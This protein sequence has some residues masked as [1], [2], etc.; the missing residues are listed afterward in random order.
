MERLLAESDASG[1]EFVTAETVTIMRRYF[2]QAN[3]ISKSDASP[4]L[5]ADISVSVVIATYDRPDSLHKC[6]RSLLGQQTSRSIEVIVVDNHPASHLTPPVLAEFPEVIFV[7]DPRQGLS[8]ARNAGIVA[9]KGEIIIT[10]D[11]DV[12]MPS[13]WLE[14]VTPFV[15][16]DVMVVTGNV[17]PIELETPAQKLFELY[18]GLQRGFRR[19]EADGNWF[20]SFKRCAVP[21]WELGSTAN[22]AFRASLFSDSQIGLFDKRLVQVQRRAAAKTPTCSIRLS[23]AVIRFSTSQ[24]PMFGTSAA[25]ISQTFADKSTQLQQGSRGIT[26]NDIDPRS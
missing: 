21:T 10:T 8:Y 26:F 1:L 18:G 5:P 22:A 20:E 12:S 14:K 23:R 25:E 2:M 19:Q 13:C 11:D 3:E 17:L 15:R 9:S 16:D 6:L 4:G 7:N 24:K